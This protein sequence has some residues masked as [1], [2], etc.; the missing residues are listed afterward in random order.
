MT[1]L[2]SSLLHL[3]QTTVQVLGLYF[4]AIRRKARG[5]KSLSEWGAVRSVPI[6]W[7]LQLVPPC[8][9]LQECQNQHIPC[10]S[11]AELREQGMNTWPPAENKLY[12]CTWTLCKCKYSLAS[13]KQFW[14][15]ICVSSLPV[16]QSL[17]ELL[18]FFIAFFFFP[19]I[20]ENFI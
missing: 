10:E 7:C 5:R 9:S 12:K 1:A 3:L 4:F 2:F 17:L 19:R 18:V 15:S 13:L 6:V 20:M 8:S 16:R 14:V 11:C